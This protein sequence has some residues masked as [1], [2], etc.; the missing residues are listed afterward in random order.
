MRD[1]IC[2]QSVSFVADDLTTRITRPIPAAAR[3]PM[4]SPN[5]CAQEDVPCASGEAAL[6]RFRESGI[7]GRQ[8]DA[9]DHA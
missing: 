2:R 8:H 1:A 5:H 3:R 9:G 6:L 7:V 4:N